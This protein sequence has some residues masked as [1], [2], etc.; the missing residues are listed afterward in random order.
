MSESLQVNIRLSTDLL[1]DIA[2]VAD[3][4]NISRA[5]WIRS[6]LAREVFEQKQHLLRELKTKARAAPQALKIE[7]TILSEM[8]VFESMIQQTLEEHERLIKKLTRRK[9]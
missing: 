2:E 1:N 3:M 5:N 7:Q 6:T 8:R 4:L 9:P